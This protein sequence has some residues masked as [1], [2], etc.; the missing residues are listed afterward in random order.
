MLKPNHRLNAGE[1]QAL[2]TLVTAL[3]LLGAEPEP[4]VQRAMIKLERQLKLIEPG[5]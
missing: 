5:I 3:R 1:L 2:I 4:A